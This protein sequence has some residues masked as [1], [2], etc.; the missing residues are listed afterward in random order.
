MDQMNKHLGEKFK[1][2]LTPCSLFCPNS[3]TDVA[4]ILKFWKYEHIS[5]CIINLE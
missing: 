1:I 3:I 2:K 4:R 5:L